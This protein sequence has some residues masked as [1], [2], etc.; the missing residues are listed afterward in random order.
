MDARGVEHVLVRGANRVGTAV[1]WLTRWPV[2]QQAIVV[3]T[4][5]LSDT[6]LVGFYNHVPNAQRIATGC[7]VRW[8]GERPLETAMDEVRQRGGGRVGV[9][10]PAVPDTVDLNAAYA[11]L[12]LT[13]SGEEIDWIRHA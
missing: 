6:L 7:E 10:G 3:V 11:R 5:G 13:K 1:G 9:I 8:V 2:T 12:R 4:P